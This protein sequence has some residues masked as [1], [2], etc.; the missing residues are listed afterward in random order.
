MTGDQPGLL[1]EDEYGRIVRHGRVLDSPVQVDG[2]DHEGRRR[3]ALD[4]PHGVAPED[5][6]RSHGWEPGAPLAAER[7]LGDPHAVVLSY[8]VRPRPEGPEPLPVVT[9]PVDAGIELDPDEPPLVRTRV[10]AYAVVIG[11]LGV[12]LA[13]ASD[14]TNAAGAWGLPGGGVEPGEDPAAAVVREVWEETGQD[15]MRPRLVAVRSHHWIGLSPKG[16]LEDFQAV[17]LVYRAELRG[18]TPVVVHDRDGTTASAA[19]VPRDAVWGEELRLAPAW[20]DLAD[21]LPPDLL[22]PD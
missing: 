3:V 15:I 13:E 18:G 14:R 21:L 6:L 16:V 4:L 19:W 10:A 9:T 22:P 17:R 12:L 5:L 2:Y 7:S 11:P 8:A 20:A 1:S